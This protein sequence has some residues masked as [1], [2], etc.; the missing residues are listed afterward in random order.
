LV[1]IDADGGGDEPERMSAE[2]QGLG[3]QNGESFRA[4][5]DFHLTVDLRVQCPVIRGNGQKGNQCVC[6]S[7]PCDHCRHGNEEAC[8]GGDIKGG[9]ILP[10]IARPGQPPRF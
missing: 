8:G 2:M 7:K 9:P 6:E 1:E 4:S 3:Q 10:G 5:G